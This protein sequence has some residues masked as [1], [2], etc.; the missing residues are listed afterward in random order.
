MVG[1]GINDAPALATADIG[2]A[3]G[4]GTDVAIETADITLM[5]GDL[6]GVVTRSR[7]AERRCER[8]GKT[9]SGL[10]Y[11]IQR[12][13]RSRRSVCSPRGSRC[14]DGVQLRVRCAER[15]EAATG[16]TVIKMPARSER[17][18]SDGGRFRLQFSFFPR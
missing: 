1:D 4:T 11:T 6:N 10:S 7:S 2:M 17:F 18:N 13:F 12:A 16:L 14:G 9:C 15:S 8:L 3:I 5:R